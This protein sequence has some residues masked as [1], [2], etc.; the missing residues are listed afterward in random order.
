MS[1]CSL[2]NISRSSEATRE[3]NQVKIWCSLIVLLLSF[4]SCIGLGGPRSSQPLNGEVTSGQ[5]AAHKELPFK[6]LLPGAFAQLPLA[7][8]QYLE[9]REIVIPQAGCYSE[10]PHNVICGQFTS[11]TTIDWAVLCSDGKESFILV[12]PGGKTKRIAEL[13]RERE[14]IFISMDDGSHYCRAIDVVGATYILD[15]YLAYGGPEPPTITHNAINDIYIGKASVV[16]YFDGKEWLRL[17]G[18]D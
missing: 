12:F 9:A 3:V 13:M 14:D 1:C 8:R 11:A 7:V 16:Q 17:Q 4:T 10:V 5:T 18:A 15:H 2:V 6:F